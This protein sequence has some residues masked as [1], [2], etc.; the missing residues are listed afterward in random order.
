MS[1]FINPLISF[2]IF[3]CSRRI[4][5]PETAFNHEAILMAKQAYI[6]PN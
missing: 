4:T 5:L 1:P 2:H 6:P 3:H